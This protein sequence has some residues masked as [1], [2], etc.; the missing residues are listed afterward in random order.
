MNR[1]NRSSKDKESSLFY[2]PSLFE[3]CYSLSD[4]RI[5][6]NDNVKRW[7][8]LS[9]TEFFIH[10]TTVVH[11]DRTGLV[12]VA[13]KPTPTE[14]SDRWSL[15]HGNTFPDDYENVKTTERPYHLMCTL[16]NRTKEK[17]VI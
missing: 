5:T 15:S 6:F 14:T 17:F 13:Y 4:N 8:I 10:Q 1:R 2:N 16:W 9:S 11:P 7:R 12:A 3:D